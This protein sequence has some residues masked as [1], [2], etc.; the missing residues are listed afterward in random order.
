MS[1]ECID[2]WSNYEQKTKC[3]GLDS[4]ALETLLLKYHFNFHSQF[5]TPALD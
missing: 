2:D 5:E 3:F 4:V 1:Y